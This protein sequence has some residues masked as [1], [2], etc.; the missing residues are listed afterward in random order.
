MTHVPEGKKNNSSSIVQTN[1]CPNPPFFTIPHLT[2]T[3]PHLSYTIPHLT[4]PSLISLHHPS[5]HT[6]SLI[7]HTPSLI[8]HTPSLISL[9][10][11][12]SHT[13]SLSSHTHH[14]SSHYTIPHLTTPPLISTLPTQTLTSWRKTEQVE[15]ALMPNLSSFFPISRPA[16]PRS[17]TKEVI[18]LY[19]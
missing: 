5:S 10:H 1:H 19:P 9:H 18:P 7:S 12:S 4:T 17:T 13:P 14:P 6:P 8:S 15:E 2:Y 16:V 3:I 11:P